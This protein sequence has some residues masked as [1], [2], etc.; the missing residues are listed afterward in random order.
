[1]AAYARLAVHV[2]VNLQPGQR[3]LINCLVEHAPLARIAAAEAH[4]HA[5][6]RKRLLAHGLGDAILRA[7]PRAAR[8]SPEERHAAGINHSSVH[9][10][11]MIGSPEV[12][13]SGVAGE[14]TETPILVDADW[15][16]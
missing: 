4:D 3:L 2:G 15:V 16:L 9:T 6:R 1:M 7:A 10:D 13:V 14:G 12:A 5:P 11:L 8:L